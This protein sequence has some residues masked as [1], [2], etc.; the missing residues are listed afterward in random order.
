M[1]S[2]NVGNLD[3]VLRICSGL[4]LIGLAAYGT[5]GP[6]GYIGFV[7]LATGIWAMC[8]LYKLL[9]ISTTSR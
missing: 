6:W 9:G 1:A 7:A 8:P 3:R 4:L 2:L 5:I